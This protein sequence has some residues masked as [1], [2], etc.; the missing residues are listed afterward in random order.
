MIVKNNPYCQYKKCPGL[1][2]QKQTTQI[3]RTNYRCEEC[4]IEKGV[5]V[6]LCNTV[7]RGLDGKQKKIQCHIKYHAGIEVEFIVGGTE[8]SAVSDLTEELS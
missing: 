8:S 1:N 5:D 2:I 4:S 6:W 7:K 3:Y